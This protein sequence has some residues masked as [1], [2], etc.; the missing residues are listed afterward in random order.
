MSIIKHLLFTTLITYALTVQ[1]AV[2]D[3]LNYLI[4]A[5]QAE[6]F[7]INNHAAQTGVITDIIASLAQKKPLEISPQVMPFKRYLYEI[8][9]QTYLNWIS[10]GSPTWRSADGNWTQNKRLSNQSLFSAKHIMTTLKDNDQITGFNNALLGKTVILLKGFKYSGLEPMIEQ[11]QMK[12]LES[13][14][15]KS[16]LLA[17]KNS[18]GDL[19]IEMKSRVLYSLKQQQIDPTLFK[20]TSISDTIAPIDIH[21][22]YGDGVAN[23]LIEWIDMQILMMKANGEID[24]ILNRYQ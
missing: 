6:P 9:K 14:S 15:H 23:E 1:T 4:I 2:A 18:R 16:A 5:N 17:L 3:K 8:E 19:F 22:S 10:Y 24:D 21:F 20:F 7:Q 11:Y 12:V 13:N